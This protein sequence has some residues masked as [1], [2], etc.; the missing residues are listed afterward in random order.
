MH[1][2]E[3]SATCHLQDKDEQDRGGGI[4]AE[5]L[6][7]RQL[8]DRPQHESREVGE[9][10]V[11]QRRKGEQKTTNI[12]IISESHQALCAYTY[13]RARGTVNSAWCSNHNDNNNNNDN[14]VDNVG[15]NASALTGDGNSAAPQGKGQPL[16]DRQPGIR[17]V[18]RRQDYKLGEEGGKS[19]P[20]GRLICFACV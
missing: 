1:V 12:D 19:G 2:L 9:G 8:G 11:C 17:V 3:V 7:R 5:V 10:G 18:E 16:F 20:K 6:H 4:D 13:V 14:S 15:R